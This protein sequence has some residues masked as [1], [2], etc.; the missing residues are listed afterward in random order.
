MFDW[1]LKFDQ[2]S[3][4][5]ATRYYFVAILVT[6]TIFVY[7]ILFIDPPYTLANRAHQNEIDWWLWRLVEQ[8]FY[9]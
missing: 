1:M 6:I 8:F 5:R 7:T 9:K 2:T 3:R 4:T